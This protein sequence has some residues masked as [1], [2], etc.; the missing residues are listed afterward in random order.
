METDFMDIETLKNL[1]E[2]A[3]G[4]PLM[5]GLFIIGV[6]IW[7]SVKSW[8]QS[9]DI[10][11]LK[12][13]LGELE[14]ML[15][16]LAFY[17]SEPVGDRIIRATPQLAAILGVAVADIVDK[18]LHKVFDPHILEIIRDANDIA[19]RAGEAVTHNVN[20]R[21]TICTLA[22]RCVETRDSYYF[23]A[24]IHRQNSVLQ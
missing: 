21:G 12:N 20:I 17:Q 23:V 7:I 22:I 9:K 11:A 10:R 4:N 16:G 13:K 15:R 1:G 8:L 2:A 19:Q 18:P 24:N 6:F 3:K 5:G 14:G